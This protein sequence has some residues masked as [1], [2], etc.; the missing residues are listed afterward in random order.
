MSL[1]RTSKLQ[2]LIYRQVDTVN[3]DR[4]LTVI[5]NSKKE[6]KTRIIAGTQFVVFSDNSTM[7]VDSSLLRKINTSLLR[8]LVLFALSIWSL[9]D[10]LFFFQMLKRQRFETI[11][12]KIN[13]SAIPK[14]VTLQQFSIQKWKHSW[15]KSVNQGGEQ[16]LQIDKVQQLEG[17]NYE[18]F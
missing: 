3:S 5:V 15:G 9:V 13:K 4:S 11:E 6:K 10:I 7:R 17:T 14:A 12:E 16:Y 1:V 2:T 8:L 18:Q